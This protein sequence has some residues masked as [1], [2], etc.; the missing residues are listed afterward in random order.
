MLLGIAALIVVFW[1]IGLAAHIAGGFINFLLVVAIVLVITHL[2][3][4][5]NHT[6]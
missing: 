3:S 6:M 1:L 4:R 5:R 2:L